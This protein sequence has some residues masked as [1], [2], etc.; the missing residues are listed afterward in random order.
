MNQR[1]HTKQYFPGNRLPFFLH[2][3]KRSNKYSHHRAPYNQQ[4]DEG[5]G[6]FESFCG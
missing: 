5:F 2:I 3:G 6:H 4:P 1:H